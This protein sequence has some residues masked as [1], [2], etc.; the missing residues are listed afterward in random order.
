MR[1]VALQYPHN[2]PLFSSNSQSTK[3][4]AEPQN[5]LFYQPNKYSTVF[6][7]FN[8]DHSATK[9]E[10]IIYAHCYSD[11]GSIEFTLCAVA[12]KLDGRVITANIWIYEMAQVEL[13]TRRGNPHKSSAPSFLGPPWETRNQ[14]FP[15]V[16][17]SALAPRN[18]FPWTASLFRGHA[19][20]DPSSR[21][22]FLALGTTVPVTA[23]LSNLPQLTV[24]L[25]SALVSLRS[26]DCTD[27]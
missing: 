4:N 15:C 26:R 12:L 22:T 17:N 3:T 11:F 2:Q 1:T 19:S 10:F 7:K 9:K 13:V 8:K 16:R 23:N 6:A 21:T 25:E 14:R 20:T 27:I 24:A 18:T 5:L